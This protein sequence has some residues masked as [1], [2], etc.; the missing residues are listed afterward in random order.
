MAKTCKELSLP[1]R[2][3]NCGKGKKRMQGVRR[4]ARVKGKED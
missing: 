3:P 4:G 2:V 1:E